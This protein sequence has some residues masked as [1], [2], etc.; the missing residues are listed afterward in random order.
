MAVDDVARETTASMSAGRRVADLVLQIPLG[1][2][3]RVAAQAV[4]DRPVAR[5]GVQDERAQ[6]DV[7]LE[8]LRDRLGDRLAV[9]LVVMSAIARV[10]RP[11]R[12]FAVERDADRREQLGEQALPRRASRR[13]PSPPPRSSP[14]EQVWPEAAARLEVVARALELGRREDI[15][16]CASSTPA[17]SSSNV[18]RSFS[19]AVMRSRARPSSRANDSSC[20]FASKPSCAKRRTR[21]IVERIRS[22][23]STASASS[24]RAQA[25]SGPRICSR[26]AFAPR[27][28]R[29]SPAR[30][31][32]R[33]R[34]RAPRDPRR[35]G[36]RSRSLEQLPLEPPC[37][38]PDPERHHAEQV[39]DVDQLV[40]ADVPSVRSRIRSTPW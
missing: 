31:R 26:N 25:A 2:P 32:D 11:A 38:E 20:V 5:D 37:G 3:R 18:R 6:A 40:P 23:S 39:R 1:D 14:V 9:T 8:R 21:S 33:R 36:R 13:A 27:A 15:T 34:R 35:P 16:A 28:P 30:S 10:P 17:H 19:T 12:L 24:E 29:S 7:R 4:L 22:S